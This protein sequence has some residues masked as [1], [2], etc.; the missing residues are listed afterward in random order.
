MLKTL[1]PTKNN[2]FSTARKYL[3]GRDKN[4]IFIFLVLQSRKNQECSF[5]I[6]HRGSRIKNSNYQDKIK[7]L[8]IKI[9]KRK[10]R[11]N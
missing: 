3:I 7:I 9:L 6:S 10:K 8:E 4:Q 1:Y 5:Q 11:K 2:K